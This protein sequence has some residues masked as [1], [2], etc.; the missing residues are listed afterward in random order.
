MVLLTWL[1]GV[2]RGN[3]WLFLPD[4]VEVSDVGA[5]LETLVSR[6]C[7]GVPVV[8]L[9]IVGVP[10]ALAGRDSLSQ[11]FVV[12]RLWWWFIAPC[13]ANSVSSERERL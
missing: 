10:A 3:T 4:L 9:P 11:E 13:V 1:L 2:S 5:C 12:G 6:G 8:L 7:S